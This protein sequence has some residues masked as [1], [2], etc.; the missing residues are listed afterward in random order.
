MSL[1]EDIF[2]EVLIKK[3]GKKPLFHPVLLY[4][5]HR[6]SST[7]LASRDFLM[8]GMSAS[9]LAA[10]VRKGCYKYISI[11]KKGNKNKLRIEKKRKKKWKH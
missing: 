11:K 2:L 1:A 7:F 10:R 5:S 9:F 8:Y 4:L 3:N 6:P